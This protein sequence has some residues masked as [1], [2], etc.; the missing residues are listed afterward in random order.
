MANPKLP[1]GAGCWIH[2]S[3]PRSLSEVAEWVAGLPE[4]VATA[5]LGGARDGENRRAHL[6]TCD[7]LVCGG[8]S[9]APRK[10]L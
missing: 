3:S 6:V 9:R 8:R 1:T 10:S 2:I 4:E 5:V 7:C